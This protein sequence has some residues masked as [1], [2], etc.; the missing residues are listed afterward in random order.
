MHSRTLFRHWNILDKLGDAELLAS[1]HQDVIISTCIEGRYSFHFYKGFSNGR[2]AL[3]YIPKFHDKDFDVEPMT[4][5]TYFSR[6]K[7]TFPG[8]RASLSVR[9]FSCFLDRMLTSCVDR[10]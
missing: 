9:T 3:A 8:G 5:E 2:K 6:I 7:V 4:F 10:V 1:D